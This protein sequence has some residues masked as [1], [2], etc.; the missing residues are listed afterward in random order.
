MR[1]FRTIAQRNDRAPPHRRR[2]AQGIDVRREASVDSD[3]VLRIP[4]DTVVDVL[5]VRPRAHPTALW[6]TVRRD[7]MLRCAALYL[8]APRFNG[9]ATRSSMLRRARSSLKPPRAYPT[10]SQ[11][12]VCMRTGGRTAHGVAL[13]MRCTRGILPLSCCAL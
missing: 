5:E 7:G 3:W 4:G 12:H 6:C 9:V 11:S 13:L 10:Q 8:V 2:S 1:R